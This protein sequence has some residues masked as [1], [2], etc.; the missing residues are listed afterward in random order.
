MQVQN[1]AMENCYICLE[2]CSEK[3]PC[4]CKSPIHPQCMHDMQQIMHCDTCTIC[5]T[6]YIRSSKT[7][8]CYT[9]TVKIIYVIAFYIVAGWCG[10]AAALLTGYKITQFYCFWSTEHI[11]GV[12]V[13]MI[14]IACV[15]ITIN[16]I[17]MI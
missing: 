8:H 9:C 1:I 14:T 2:A 10:K 13:V 7:Q 3:S 11:I 5:K 6:P 15:Y 17:Q 12:L 16:T 4:E